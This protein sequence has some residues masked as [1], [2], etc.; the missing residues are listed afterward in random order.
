MGF[1]DAV[2][3]ALGKYATFSGRARRSEYWYFAL[4]S[5]VV[6]LVTSIL[7]GILGTGFLYILSALALLV[8]SLAVGVR[9]LHDISKSGWLLL[10][11]LIPF[12]GFIVLI[13]WFVQDS[14]GPNEHG[15]S[16]KGAP[17]QE[18]GYPATA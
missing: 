6:G 8:P 14:H 9:R 17:M 2:K 7:D 4:F 12:V 10:V 3:Q 5:F 1:G 15:P 18:P 16:P 13:V 11:G